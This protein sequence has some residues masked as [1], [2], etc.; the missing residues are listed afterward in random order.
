MKV[1]ELGA[2][3]TLSV[4]SP[5]CAA[6]FSRQSLA[7]GAGG[8]SEA[9]AGGRSTVYFRARGPAKGGG[10]PIKNLNSLGGR[11]VF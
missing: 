2:P 4:A 10:R 5:R 3:N 8:R 7:R 11:F 9:A 1:I 6:G